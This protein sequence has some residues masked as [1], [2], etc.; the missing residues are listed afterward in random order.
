MA[1]MQHGTWSHIEIPTASVENAK[2]FYGGLL[3]WTFN[4][5]TGM[6]YTV[7]K[8][9]D[10]E[11]GGGLWNPPAGVPRMVTNYVTV[12]SL[13]TSSAKLQELGGRVMSDKREV[14][15]HG[16][17]MVVSDPDG[18]AFALWQSMKPLPPPA[19]A[20]KAPARRKPTAKASAKGKKKKKRS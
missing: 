14:P 16:W 17:F 9:G 7:Y 3:G 10:G 19:P 2:K 18:N 1:G 15:G 6:D 4:D 8:T 11:V 12:L 20:K 5:M 13:E